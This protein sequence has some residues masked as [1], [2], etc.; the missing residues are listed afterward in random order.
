MNN[1]MVEMYFMVVGLFSLFALATWQLTLA[2]LIFLL[3]L[4]V[5]GFAYSYH[6]K[7]DLLIIPGKTYKDNRTGELIKVIEANYWTVS[8][9]YE[10]DHQLYKALIDDFKK[11]FEYC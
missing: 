1:M 3:L 8:Y 10:N 9:M 11:N 7:S 6:N 2:N 5:V 4:W